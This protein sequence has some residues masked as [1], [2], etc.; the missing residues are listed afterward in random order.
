MLGVGTGDWGLLHEQQLFRLKTGGGTGVLGVGTGDGTYTWRCFTIN[1]QP[2]RL[3]TGGT[4][5]IHGDVR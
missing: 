1:K 4:G 2:F 5:V 3:V